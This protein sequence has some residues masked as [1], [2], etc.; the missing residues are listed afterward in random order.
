MS[1]GHAPD[2]AIGSPFIPEDMRLQRLGRIAERIGWLAMA[3]IVLAALLGLFSD[4]MLSQR[5]IVAGDLVLEQQRF[6]RVERDSA[7]TLTLPPHTD[8]A[9]LTVDIDGTIL[10]AMSV[11]SIEPRPLASQPLASGVRYSFAGSA[12]GGALRLDLR[13]RRPGT[14]RG[15]LS[16]AEQR[17][18]FYQFVYP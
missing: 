7:M 13:P 4:G 17:L 10:A 15:S 8:T 2:A 5:R 14:V 18:D 3:A 16:V 12:E 9:P 11:E 6:G 1:D